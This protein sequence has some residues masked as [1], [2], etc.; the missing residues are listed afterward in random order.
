MKSVWHV[1][2]LWNLLYVWKQHSVANFLTCSAYGH[3]TNSIRIS[4]NWH[5][6]AKWT[7]KGIIPASSFCH[8]HLI[9]AIEH[10]NRFQLNLHTNY[11]GIDLLQSHQSQR[12]FVRLDRRQLWQ[13]KLKK[14]ERIEDESIDRW[15]LF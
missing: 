2:I 11:I 13:I 12:I 15:T 4:F 5:C 14:E 10:A 6:H 1:L 3:M 8:A 9:N 7:T